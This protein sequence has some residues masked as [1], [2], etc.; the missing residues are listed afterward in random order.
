MA[1]RPRDRQPVLEPGH[2]GRNLDVPGGR[3]PGLGFQQALAIVLQFTNGLAHVV[4]GQM[5]G[6]LAEALGDLRRPTQRELLEGA[7]VEIAVVEEFLELRHVARQEAPV[8]AHAVAAHRR[9]SGL[10]PGFEKTQSFAFGGSRVD[11]AC[12]YSSAQS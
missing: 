2:G 1:G 5:A 9:F 11:G 7:H 4:H 8:L 3:E 6:G 12:R 10:E